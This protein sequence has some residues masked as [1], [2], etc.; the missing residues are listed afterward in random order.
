[1]LQLFFTRFLYS[2]LHVSYKNTHSCTFSINFSVN[3]SAILYCP[4][5]KSV[6]N[7]QM[8]AARRDLDWSATSAR[9]LFDGDDAVLRNTV[10]RSFRHGHRSL[11]AAAARFLCGQTLTVIGH[12]PMTTFFCVLLTDKIWYRKRTTES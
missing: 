4:P 7:T 12:C 5:G 3:S 6:S 8:S 9:L 1:M 10:R 11:P 2:R